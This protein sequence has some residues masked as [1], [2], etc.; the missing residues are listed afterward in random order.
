MLS[1]N[2]LK[3]RQN[4]TR[5]MHNIEL[6]K[7]CKMDNQLMGDFLKANRDFI[8]SIIMHFKGGI[9]E[10]TAKFRVSEE[11][12]Y[13]HACIGILTAIKDFNFDRGIKFTT[14]VVRP[15]LWEINHLLYSDSQSVRLSRGAVELIKRMAEIEDTLGYR[16]AEREM[17][18]L[19][20]VSVERYREI[21]MFSD[22]LEHYDALESFEIADKERRNIEEE[23]TNRIYVQ[24]LLNDPIFTDF[25]KMVM[26][27]VLEDDN[28]TN[29][30]IA[31]RLNVYPMTINRTF[32]KIRAKIEN[33][34]ASLRGERDAT[35]S[36]YEQ[37]ISIIAQETRERN[38]LLC[39]DDI[40][41]LLEICGYD[42]KNY[43][44]RILYYIR[45]KATQKGA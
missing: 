28:Y 3:L 25:E 44:T 40:T 18:G 6:L 10:L 4:G 9:E 36:K 24:Q 7:A 19:L 32:H 29:S 5:D 30:Q 16:P 11:E 45:Q 20:N 39:I 34:Q 17:A 41:E 26:R 21:A 27:L 23:V 35:A 42:P 33:Q 14:Y 13:Q 37:E 15:I 38:K 1:A 12:L 2:Y 8:F 31:E 22:E 43:T